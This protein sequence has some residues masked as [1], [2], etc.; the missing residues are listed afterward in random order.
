MLLEV[1]AGVGVGVVGFVNVVFIFSLEVFFLVAEL[2]IKV[3]GFGIPPSFSSFWRKN[4]RLAK[5]S[6]LPKLFF[7]SFG[8][9]RIFY[10]YKLI[11]VLG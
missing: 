3:F 4:L 9:L 2:L 5:N 7:S 11:K 8:L 10:L 1:V 6:S